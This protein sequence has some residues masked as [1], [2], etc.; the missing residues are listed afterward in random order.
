MRTFIVS[1][2]F[3]LVVTCMHAGEFA[4]DGLR[5][6]IV[7]ERNKTCEVARN[8]DMAGD[9]VIP[10]KVFYNK[11]EFTVVSIANSAFFSCTSLSSIKIP[12]SVTSIGDWAFYDCTSLAYVDMPDSL[13]SVGDWAFYGC[14]ALTSIEIYDS[15]TSIGY[16]A[17]WECPMLTS[18]NVGLKNP[19]YSSI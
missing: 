19:T 11:L 17:F 8:N 14:S 2:I 7:N 3:T 12:A 15:T 4:Y 5:Y 6:S 13:V 1:F 9:V 16:A 18:I 10:S